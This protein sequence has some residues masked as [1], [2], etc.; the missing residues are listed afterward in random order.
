M[1]AFSPPLFLLSLPFPSLLSLLSVL[2]LFSLLPSPPYI[3][4]SP[5]LPSHPLGAPQLLLHREAMRL[6]LCL[7]LGS[8]NIK[9]FLQVVLIFDPR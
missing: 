8:S 4:S 2:P 5:S 7:N 1:Y 3:P 9:V 6:L